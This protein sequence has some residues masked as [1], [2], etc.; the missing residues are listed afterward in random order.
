[1]KK[2]R[3]SKKR[4]SRKFTK[5]ERDLLRD[6]GISPDLAKQYGRRFSDYPQGIFYLAT[7]GISPK[8][9]NRYH[10]RFSGLGVAQLIKFGISP[11]EAKKYPKE[12][13]GQHI[14]TLKR[15]GIG[16]KKAV[17][18]IYG[19]M[20]LNEFEI[21]NI[22]TTKKLN[23]IKIIG[24]GAEGVILLL[25][26][27]ATK[28]SSS[29]DYEF[30]LLK[31]IDDTHKSNQKNVV[32]VIGEPR[33]YGRK[34]DMLSAKFNE[35]HIPRKLRTNFAL[36]I[37]NIKGDSLESI[38][39]IEDRLPYEE[40]VK[41]STDILNGLLEMR[42]AGIYQHRDIRP[43]NIMIDSEN[44]RAVIIDLGIATT[45]EF[46]GPKDNRRYGGPNDLVSL[47]QVMY[48]MATGKHIFA[49][50]KSMEKTIYAQKIKDERDKAYSKDRGLYGY[51]KKVET[52]ITDSKLK[53]AIELCL[54]SSCKEQAYKELADIL[55]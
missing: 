35:S 26:D 41:Y 55:R 44:D 19:Y 11:A 25:Y 34:E 7:A 47:G 45:E 4:Y 23:D 21:E 37:E 43:A 20:K 17:K 42:A 24:T 52:N 51:L 12:M 38:L 36:E 16:P 9:A 14:Y 48:K 2:N 32:K 29:I 13:D 6:S 54:T 53:N 46:A 49:K 22:L 1:M 18:S 40:T 27:C 31:R 10:E 3:T 15:L 39:K 30:S 50:S 33:D 8:I 5:D 28:I